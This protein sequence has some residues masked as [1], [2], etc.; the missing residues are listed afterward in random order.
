MIGDRIQKIRKNSGLTVREFAEKA[1]ITHSMVS[2]F[3]NNQKIPGR[4]V[5]SKIARAFNIPEEELLGELK[6][7]VSSSTISKT[8]YKEKLKLAENLK[9]E[10]AVKLISE[11]IEICLEKEELDDKFDTI[12]TFVK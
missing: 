1:E 9:S 4:K 5:V 12:K 10:K 3:E 8:D 2:N 6:E 7:N 11:L